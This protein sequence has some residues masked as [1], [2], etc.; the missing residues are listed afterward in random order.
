MIYDNEL[1]EFHAQICSTLA[2][3]RRLMIVDTLRKGEKAVNEIAEAIG[4][5]QTTVS[6]H[7]ALMRN[8]GVV[9]NRREGQNVYYQINNPKIIAAYEL[10]HEVTL[11]FLESRAALHPQFSKGGQ[12]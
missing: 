1:Y 10:M 3:S 5:P 12:S 7:L 4:V 8:Q 9:S 2:N 11:E 6:R